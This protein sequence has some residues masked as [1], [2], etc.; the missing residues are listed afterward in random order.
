MINILWAED[1]TNDRVLI[2]Q[3]IKEVFNTTKYEVHFV[4]DGV[5]AIEFLKNKGAFIASPHP[6]VIVLDLNMPRK[7]GFE[8]LEEIKNDSRY[9]SIPIIVLSSENDPEEIDKIKSKYKINFVAKPFEYNDYI[10]VILDIEKY[11]ERVVK[12]HS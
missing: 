11:C 2:K 7:T 8:V 4:Y 1:S 12:I 10:K 3:A 5:Q 6:N 9:S